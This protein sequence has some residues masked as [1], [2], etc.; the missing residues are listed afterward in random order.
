M[1]STYVSL[2]SSVLPS[3]KEAKLQISFLESVEE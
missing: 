2:A 3:I 1:P